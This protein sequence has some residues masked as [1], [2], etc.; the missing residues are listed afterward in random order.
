MYKKANQLK[1]RFETSKGNLS[2]E[3]LW[4]LSRTQLAVIVKNLKKKL[5]ESN[6][7]DELSFLDDTAA[8]VDE[9]TQLQFDIV[10]DIYLTKKDAAEKAKND[11]VKKQE[12]QE[13][14][15]IKAERQKEAKFNMSDDELNK[16][17][18]ELSK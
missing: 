10:K 5:K 2:V 15:A 6:G 12:L 17:I 18:E 14:L 7:D 1:L 4:D 11:T 3:Q 13:L 9:L 8:Q 16:K